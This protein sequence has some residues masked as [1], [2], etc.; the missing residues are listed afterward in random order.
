MRVVFGTFAEDTTQGFVSDATQAHEAREGEDMTHGRHWTRVVR[1]RVSFNH[2][3]T[4]RGSG[5]AGELRADRWHT[6]Y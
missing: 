5:Y 4:A 2:D 3:E 1:N 6:V